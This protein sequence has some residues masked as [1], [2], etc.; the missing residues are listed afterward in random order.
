[1]S[2]R[3]ERESKAPPRPKT[4]VQL[5]ELFEAW[6]E[7]PQLDG[8]PSEDL[9]PSAKVRRAWQLDPF[10]LW[11]TLTFLM[12]S[13]AALAMWLTRQEVAY[14]MQRGQAPL[15]G[16]DL[17]TQWKEG[18]RSLDLP[19]NRHVDL[20]GLFATYE[21]DGNTQDGDEGASETRRYFLCPLFDIVVRSLED[22]PP[23]PYHRAASIEVDEEFVELIAARRAFPH[24]LTV[25]I[26][27]TGRLLRAED[28]PRWNRRPIR[29]FAS[30]AH[31][32]PSQMWLLI[33]GDR[34]EH[35]GRF[36]LLWALACAVILSSLGMLLFAWRRR[37]G[38]ATGSGP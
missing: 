28:V 10:R 1:M 3:E 6:Q 24:D 13:L 8:D 36:V 35:H 18:K 25:T 37:R 30:M 12:V 33:E 4:D 20:R 38:R 26:D 27:V 34:P 2:D 31:L 21:A 15:M 14:W 22:V 23:K 32:D 17:A 7:P 16:G 11:I 5:A 9:A 19:S 29:Y